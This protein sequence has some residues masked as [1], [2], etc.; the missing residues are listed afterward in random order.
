[1]PPPASCPAPGVVAVY[2]AGVDV[3]DRDPDARARAEAWLTREDRTRAARF[4]ADADRRMFILGRVMARALVGAA[5]GV[6]PGAWTW[7]DAPRGR[8]EIAAPATP[9]QFNLSHSAGLVACAL[10]TGR[11]VGIDVEHL[12]RRPV[13]RQLV[14]RYCSAAE[15]DDIDACGDAWQQRF[16]RYWTLKEAYLKA[17]G[18]GVSVP[19]AEI[20]FGEVA[21]GTHA[22]P[23]ASI[24]IAFHGSLAGTDDRWT[25]ALRQ[26]TGDHILAVAADACDGGPV[27]I[28]LRPM[29]VELLP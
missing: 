5:L 24:R 1:M 2:Y 28:D 17:R 3:L 12:G 20:E 26:P 9:L 4:R 23:R 11:A 25:F 10:A 14:R 13:D 8:P 15:A 22:A 7:R 27:S 18:L 19:L 21:G 16:L 29:P 6:A